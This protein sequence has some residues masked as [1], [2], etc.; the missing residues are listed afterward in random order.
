LPGCCRGYLGGQ[1]WEDGLGCQ[2]FVL[3]G[4]REREQLVKGR[5]T[6]K[7]ISIPFF[8]KRKSKWK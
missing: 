3:T 2:V 4:F 5:V 8:S 7:Y 6:E 1:P